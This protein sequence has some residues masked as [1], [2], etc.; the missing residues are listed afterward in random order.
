MTYIPPAPVITTDTATIVPRPKDDPVL[1]SPVTNYQAAKDKLGSAHT[2]VFTSISGKQ[3]QGT[4]RVILFRQCSCSKTKAFEL[5][6][7]E[8]A[9]ALYLR[10]K[11]REA[12]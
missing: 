1:H 8:A 6:P 5:L 12:V 2:C 11:Q 10:L 3:V 7:K 9:R 4:N